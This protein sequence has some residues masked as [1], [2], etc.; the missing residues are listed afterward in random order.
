MTTKLAAIEAQI[1]SF[2]AQMTN[3]TAK[4]AMPPTS[5]EQSAA[6]A[7][8]GSDGPLLI[9]RTAESAQLM[10]GCAMPPTSSE[11][12]GTSAASGSD[13]PLLTRRP[14]KASDT[15]SKKTAAEAKCVLLEAE[16]ARLRVQLDE[17]ANQAAQRATRQ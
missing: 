12:S 15:S 6:A 10:A 11:L 5:S 14:H 8:S 3:I 13:G 16:V 2:Q 7:A 17:F 9:R 4:R 1:A